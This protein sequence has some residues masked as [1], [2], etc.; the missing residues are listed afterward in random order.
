[1]DARP[2]DSAS[3][4]AMTAGIGFP[5]EQVTLGASRGPHPPRPVRSDKG[6]ARRHGWTHLKT[7]PSSQAMAS[8]VSYACPPEANRL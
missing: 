7:A 3:G 4:S 1:L 6:T 2:L 5:D 8:A